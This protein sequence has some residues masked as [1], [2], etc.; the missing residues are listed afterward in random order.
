[1]TKAKMVTMQLRLDRDVHR[2]I[3]DIARLSGRHVD[4]VVA[5]LLAIGTLKHVTE[6]ARKPKRRQR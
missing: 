2:V 3:H 1:M 4:D 6:T 5:V